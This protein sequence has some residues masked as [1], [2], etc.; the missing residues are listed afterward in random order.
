MNI[1]LS[2]PTKQKTITV[3]PVNAK[4]EPTPIFGSIEYVVSV[5][6]VA[7]VFANDN[8]S[9]FDVLGIAPGTTGITVT[10]TT[11]SGAKLI[12]NITVTVGPA[13]V[14]VDPEEATDVI[15]VEGPESEQQ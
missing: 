4:G 7:S 15:F 12:K 6:G 8:G 2:T 1:N 5:P 3:T 13:V 9:A 14:T 10:A 11:K